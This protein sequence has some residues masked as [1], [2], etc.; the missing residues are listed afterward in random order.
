[1][2]TNL[3]DLIR[4]KTINSCLYGG[5]RKWSIQELIEACS[6]ALAESRGRYEPVSER[7]IRDDIRVLRSD[8]LGFN[9]PI[10]Q[11]KRLYFYSDPKFSILSLRITDEGLADKIYFFLLHL[12]SEVKHPELETILEQICK[13][14]NRTYDKHLIPEEISKEE[15]LSEP[16]FRLSRDDASTYG[17]LPSPKVT[18]KDKKKPSTQ[19]T[20]EVPGYIMQKVLT[21][22]KI[23]DIVFRV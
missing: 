18:K 1:M 22:G 14:T 21:W 9:A 12:R 7:T 4:Y 20:E 10:I 11:E 5:R 13:L 15:R 2:P 6:E 3:N 16:R 23:I 19:V 17:S 8:I